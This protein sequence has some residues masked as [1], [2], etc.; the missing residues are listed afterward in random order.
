MGRFDRLKGKFKGAEEAQRWIED[1]D[2]PLSAKY[3]N[4]SLADFDR[5]CEKQESHQR[6]Q[7]AKIELPRQVQVSYQ[8]PILHDPRQGYRNPAQPIAGS[9]RDHASA[10]PRQVGPPPQA[11]RYRVEEY[12]EPD[13]SD[14]S[15][16]E[17]SRR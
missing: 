17:Y 16:E 10:K 12:E 15:M 14:V 9:S 1:P 5:A 8:R 4:M 7:Q 2:G 11:E 3:S 13:D 6:R